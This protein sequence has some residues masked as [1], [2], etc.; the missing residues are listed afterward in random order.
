MAGP[1]LLVDPPIREDRIG[2]LSSVV[3]FR[4]NDRLAHAEKVTFQSDG[5]EFPE[6]E[7]SRC[8]ATAPVADKEFA[9]TA[10]A[11]GIAAPITLYAGVKCF[12][13]PDADEVERARQAL[14][15]GR[16]Q[17]LEELLA[18]WA[19]GGAAV[20]AGST[21]KNAIGRI[22]QALDKGYRKR[23]LILMSRFDALEAG[24]EYTEGEYLRT[25]A[26]TP[27]V[28]SGWVE[29]GTVYGLGAVTVE[30][31]DVVERDVIEPQKNT[32]W[33]LA[34]QVYELLVDCEF[35]IKSAITPA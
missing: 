20:A 21:P 30:H 11:D 1:T 10:T 19:D 32:H 4:K 7:E 12:A 28:A 35:R 15:D 26:G 14:E 2:G 18:D 34:E 9:G 33:A 27:V 22:E 25:K 6:T 23:G 17:K 8:L 31:T 24:L 29:P 3:P 16:D 5:C 13:A